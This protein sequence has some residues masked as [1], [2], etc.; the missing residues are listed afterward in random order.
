MADKANEKTLGIF[1]VMA[2]DIIYYNLNDSR[3]YI[4]DCGQF[5]T[6]VSDHDTIIDLVNSYSNDNVIFVFTGTFRIY[7][8]ALKTAFMI[9]NRFK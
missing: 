4:P 5:T 7:E 6:I 9:N 3:A 1:Q 8:T 2:D